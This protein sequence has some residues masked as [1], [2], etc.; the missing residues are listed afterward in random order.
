MASELPATVG[1]VGLGL[2]GGSIGLALRDP[3]RRVVGFDPDPGAA[4]IARDRF[5]VDEIVPLA[6]VARAEVVFVA[7]PPDATVS[8]VEAVMV[9]SGE[10]TVVTDCA[11]VK[12]ELAAWAQAGKHARFVPGHPMAGHEKGGATYASAWMFRG[13]RWMITPVKATANASVRAIET[14]VKAMGAVPV[15]VDAEVHDRHV[16]TVS[17]LPHVLAALLVNLGASLE[18]VEAAGGS[19]R[20]MTRVGGV[21]P[22]LW[23]QIFMR[24]RKE[25][26]HCLRDY[27]T[28]LATIREALESDDRAGVHAILEKAERI[29]LAQTPEFA[30]TRSLKRGRR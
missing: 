12:N 8:V 7:V 3:S 5:C 22:D 21:D 11:S 23:T 14:L 6:E 25:L 30:E 27:E 1:V 15:R 2:I 29:K 10:T 28:G 16:A 13:A 17:H 20:D 9:A 24:N 19:W 4:R 26:A 18:S